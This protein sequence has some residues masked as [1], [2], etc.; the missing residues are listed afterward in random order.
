[1]LSGE[2]SLERGNGVLQRNPV[3]DIDM[4][5]RNSRRETKED[6][7]SSLNSGEDLGD[8]ERLRHKALY[9]SCAFDL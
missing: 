2:D 6:S 4:S 5:K 9:F 1:V 7:Q 3:D 8:S